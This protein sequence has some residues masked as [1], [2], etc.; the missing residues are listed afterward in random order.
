MIYQMAVRR[1][2]AF[3][4]VTTLWTQSVSGTDNSIVDSKPA[5]D[6]T[7][8]ERPN[9][10]F[11]ISDDQSWEHTSASGCKSI[12]TPNFDR[13]A[14]EGVLFNNSFCGSPGCTPSRSSVLT[15]RYP[16]Q[17][18]QAGTHAS[19]FPKQF[20]V[21]PELLE[22]AGYVVGFTG[23]G[24]GPG[25]FKAS[26]RTR[27]PA[28]PEFNSIKTKKVPASGIASFDYSANFEA[29]LKTQPKHKPFCFWYGGKEPHRK[30][31]KGSG[32]RAGKKLED[33]AVP[34]FLPDSP[35]IRSD[36][37][38][39][40]L[41]IEWFD[42][43]LGRMIKMLEDSGQLENTLIV[44]TSDNGMAF[45]RAKANAYEYGVHM[46]LAIRWEKKIPKGRVVDDLVSHTDFA[47]TFLDA[48]GVVHPAQSSD[49]PAMTGRSL[50]P[51]LRS[52][53]SGQTTFARPEIFSCRERHSSSRWN[54]LTYP[55]RCIRTADYLLIRN[56]KPERWPAGAPQ[57]FES[58]GKLGPEH[59]G[60]HDIDACPSLDYLIEHR[61]D[62]AVA[63]YFA[64]AVGHRPAIELF[65]IKQDPGCLRNLADESGHAVTRST[66][67]KQL[68]E[69][70]KKTGDPRLVGK[71]DIWDQYKRYSRMRSFPKPE[72]AESSNQQK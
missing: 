56:F 72:W 65:D 10:L 50:L 6:R 22:E 60:Y 43:H 30:F 45:P 49:T 58:N 3:V 17:L 21:Y 54:N 37:L 11:A 35:E 42:F 66:L 33:V 27:N 34:S 12:D 24:W 39:Y 41:E 15:G 47:P 32:L 13:I 4:F 29:F 44:V 28:G 51:L 69:Y 1:C 71:G 23:K 68:N 70:L 20:V 67:E 9:I 61:D 26:G 55:Q 53:Q 38:D 19:S 62:A 46:P 59:G 7:V 57:K 8:D 14:R 36:I 52:T 16:W 2:I 48:A 64:W 25:N 31:E 18:E 40:C 5:T 63:D